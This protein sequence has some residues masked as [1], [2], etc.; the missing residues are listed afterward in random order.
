MVTGLS[1]ASFPLPHGVGAGVLSPQEN[2]TV[3][4]DIPC[5]PNSW[6]TGLFN[7]APNRLEPVRP[8]SRMRIR[9]IV[10][11]WW[12]HRAHHRRPADWT[13]NRWTISD[14]VVFR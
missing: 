11:A 10:D 2:Y 8:L 5:I 14:Q 1:V 6:D 3:S 7:P 12:P 13:A 9:L 4:R